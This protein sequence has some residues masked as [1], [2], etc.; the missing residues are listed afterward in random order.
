MGESVVENVDPR[1]GSLV[2]ATW[3]N[4]G[5]NQVLIK[6]QLRTL[7]PVQELLPFQRQIRE[8]QLGASPAV[9]E[10]SIFTVTVP[11]DEA[12]RIIDITY[13]HDDSTTHILEW[14]YFPRD[15]AGDQH[16][17]AR[18]SVNM[19][20]ATPIYRSF[21]EENSSSRFAPRGPTPVEF[22]PRDQIQ[23]FDLTGATDA[24]VEARLRVRWELIP[25]PL[26]H[27]LSEQWLG[28]SI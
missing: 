20:L 10:K 12:W 17:I 18:K 24:D 5:G 22:F 19:N 14:S 28:Q 26:S 27:T 11:Q 7:L 2:W 3:T 9:G 16:M 13:E 6:G 23:I 1:L 25:V 4:R 21:S 15:G 8:Q